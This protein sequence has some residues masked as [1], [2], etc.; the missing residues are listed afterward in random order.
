MAT[1]SAH[2]AVTNTLVAATVDTITLDSYGVM[3]QIIHHGN[4]TDP[5]TFTIGA[6]ANIT[7]P[8]S[9][10]N[11]TYTVVSGTSL[12]V[13]WPLDVSGLSGGGV[14]KLISAGTAKYTVQVLNVR[15]Q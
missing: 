6:A 4:V 2:F 13:S 9:E 14:V 15:W 7:T 5:L 1:E 10:A 8:V 3:V 12:N 11:D